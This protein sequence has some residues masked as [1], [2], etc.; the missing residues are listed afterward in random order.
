MVFAGLG[1]AT[2]QR[3]PKQMTVEEYRQVLVDLGTYLDA[4]KRNTNFREQFE[5]MSPDALQTLLNSTADPRKLQRAVNGLRQHDAN[6]QSQF[7]MRTQAPVQPDAAFPS[8]PANTII[9]TSPGATCTPAYPDPNNTAW[10]N[11]VNPIITFGAFSPTDYP[12]VASQSCSLTVESNLVQTTAALNGTVTVAAIACGALPPIAS[13]VCFAA[14]AVVGV[15]GA[16][17]QGLLADCSEQ[18]GNVNAAE[19]DAG[20]HNTVTIYNAL[21]QATQG[22][23]T[24]QTDIAN[25][26]T[27]VNTG[28]SNLNTSISNAVSSINS[29]TNTDFSTLNTSISNAVLNINGNTNTDF[30]AL[31]NNLNA[32]ATQI[33]VE[34]ATLG[35]NLTTLINQLSTQ[36]TNSTDLETA[37]LKQIMKMQL[38]PDG[39][40]AIVPAILTCTGANCPNVLNKCPS[41]GCSWNNVGPLP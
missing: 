35:A 17:S 28:F 14:V 23:N 32:T 3:S 12:S 1:Q 5:A 9:D 30:T 10:Q 19:I 20:F 4:H 2:A 21:G 8:C 31:N 16:V 39:L 37:Q 7:R 36:L 27:T 38:E 33:G 41:A 13:N 11:L 6:P 22:I 25:L 18:D 34:I 40:K 26:S 24:I 29:T 15:A